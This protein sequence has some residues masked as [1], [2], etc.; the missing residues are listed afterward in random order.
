MY[1]KTKAL[2]AHSKAL[3]AH[4]KALNRTFMWDKQNIYSIRERFSQY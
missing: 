4:S 2:N 3:N 1:K